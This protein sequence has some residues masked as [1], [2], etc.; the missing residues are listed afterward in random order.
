MGWHPN[1]EARRAPIVDQ[2]RDRIMV[3]A[4]FAVAD[5]A[6]WA[7]RSG[8]VLTNSN[9]YATQAEIESKNCSGF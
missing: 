9:A 2:C 5:D 7:G 1:H 3:H 4:G 8:D 6:E